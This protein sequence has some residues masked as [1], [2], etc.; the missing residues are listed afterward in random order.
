M[1]ISRERYEQIRRAFDLL[2]KPY[3]A[4]KTKLA[5]SANALWS[6]GVDKEYWASF[7]DH[8]KEFAKNSDYGT[9]SSYE[10]GGNYSV[11]KNLMEDMALVKKKV[12]S[13]RDG[14]GTAVE[15]IVLRDSFLGFAIPTQIDVSRL[16]IP[17][18]GVIIRDRVDV[19]WFPRVFQFK[20]SEQKVCP[21]VYLLANRSQD[22]YYFLEGEV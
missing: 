9:F 12:I 5:T 6:N 16:D 8:L 4:D 18:D 13:K 3:Y 21:E 22:A 19:R 10:K 7:F 15:R 2:R 14:N 17:F 11:I 20:G 1:E